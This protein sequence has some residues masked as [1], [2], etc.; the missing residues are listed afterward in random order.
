MDIR[1]TPA[2]SME[3]IGENGNWQ[4]VPKAAADEI[5]RCH[6]RLEIDHVFQM[7]AYNNLVRV[8]I[9]LEGRLFQTD[10]IDCRDATI[11]EI[12]HGN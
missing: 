5:L 10:G 6:A 7:D 12:E 2:G 9:P 1:I 11:T 4:P 3:A 8:E